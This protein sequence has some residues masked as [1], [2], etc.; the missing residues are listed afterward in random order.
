MLSK[1]DPNQRIEPCT[2]VFGTESANASSADPTILPASS[3]QTTNAAAP[4]I[5]SISLLSSSSQPSQSLVE[6]T[7]EAIT[8]ESE[9]VPPAVCPGYEAGADENGS[10]DFPPADLPTGTEEF[11]IV[12]THVDDSGHIFGHAL[13][14]GRL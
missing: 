9:S 12:V 13:K 5:Y 6:S 7:E 3:S 14:E 8:S 4:A 10:V 2:L 1:P 11:R